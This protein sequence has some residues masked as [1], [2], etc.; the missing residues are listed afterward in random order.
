MRASRILRLSLA[1]NSA[2][3]ILSVQTVILVPT[4]QLKKFNNESNGVQRLS[5][6]EEVEHGH[7]VT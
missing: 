2:I 1:K 6:Q 3:M 4:W 5:T 7:P